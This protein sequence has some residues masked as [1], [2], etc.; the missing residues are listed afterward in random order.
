M[1]LRINTCNKVWFKSGGGNKTTNTE[2]R[3]GGGVQP[4]GGT[5]GGGASF[6]GSTIYNITGR[7]LNCN[8]GRRKI[9][10]K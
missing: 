10:D 9:E 8:Y 5:G 7:S 2:G 1:C 4:T 6:S 3:G